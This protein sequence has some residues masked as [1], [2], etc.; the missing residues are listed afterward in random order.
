MLSGSAFVLSRT[1]NI[2]FICI[3]NALNVICGYFFIHFIIFLDS[4][5]P[6]FCLLL[7]VWDVGGLLN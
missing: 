6:L 5:R 7:W 3:L 2:V 4:K 1:I